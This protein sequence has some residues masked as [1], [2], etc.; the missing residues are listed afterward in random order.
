MVKITRTL[1]LF[2]MKL[3]MKQKECETEK[4]HFML[5]KK[6][7]MLIQIIPTGEQCWEAPLS[8]LALA[9]RKNK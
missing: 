4:E 3:F 5:G 8:C 6:N 2:T 7:T 1:Y 9:G